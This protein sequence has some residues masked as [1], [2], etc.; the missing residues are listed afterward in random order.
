MFILNYLTQVLCCVALSHLEMQVF[1]DQ[2]DPSNLWS[3]CDPIIPWWSLYNLQQI[4]STIL[5]VPTMKFLIKLR[6]IHLFHFPFTIEVCIYIEI[7]HFI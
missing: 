5:N 7:L 1:Y 4:N 2:M 6:D 3:Y